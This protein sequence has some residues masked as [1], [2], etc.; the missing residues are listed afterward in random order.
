MAIIDDDLF[1]VTQ[2][3]S[4]VEV[5]NCKSLVS[6]RQWILEGLLR[7]ADIG[8]SKTN[9]CLYIMD[10]K[11]GSM[12]KE[13]FC[14]DTSGKLLHSWKTGDD[15]GDIISV[16]N[17][18]NVLVT[19]FGKNEFNEYSPQGE[20]IRKIS[21]QGAEYPTHAVKLSNGEFM[22]SAG[23]SS[24]L[25]HRVCIV[26]ALGK[27]EKSFGEE[28]GSDSDHLNQPMHLAVFTD[29]SVAVLDNGNR[30]VL[31]LEKDLQFNCILLSNK[32]HRLQNPTR[33]LLNESN[34][35]LFVADNNKGAGEIHVFHLT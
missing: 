16:S 33:L 8:S 13:V 29:G 19:C 34:N 1:V 9:R 20:M 28:K 26:D 6:S 31:L 7:P 27:V 2:R 35:L 21:L 15:Y 30:R 22:V 17:E 18:N 32:I 25:L 24:H 5:F 10:W 14:V 11:D 3:S 23:D 12:K 4:E